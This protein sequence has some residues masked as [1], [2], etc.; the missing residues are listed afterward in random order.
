MIP[1]YV[2]IAICI[3]S[4]AVASLISIL[5]RKK[6]VEKTINGNINTINRWRCACFDGVAGCVAWQETGN[7]YYRQY[8]RA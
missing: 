6:T 5:I 8:H 3:V 7:Y 1:I 2:W 4:A